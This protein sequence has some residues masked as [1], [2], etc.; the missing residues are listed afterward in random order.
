MIETQ[1]RS[2]EG[3]FQNWHTDEWSLWN[4]PGAPSLDALDAPPLLTQEGSSNR[5][6]KTSALRFRHPPIFQTDPLREFPD[7]C[8][9]SAHRRMIRPE[10]RWE[11]RL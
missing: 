11:S 2:C 10:F 4:R 7:P 5:N 6:L 8:Q 3:W 1:S 9:P